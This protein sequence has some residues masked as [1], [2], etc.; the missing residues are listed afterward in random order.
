MDDV[1]IEAIDDNNVR[2]RTDRPGER[3]TSAVVNGRDLIREVALKLNLGDVLGDE[4]VEVES[5]DEGVGD[6]EA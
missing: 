2:I 6:S 3:A 5:A 1:S 4:P